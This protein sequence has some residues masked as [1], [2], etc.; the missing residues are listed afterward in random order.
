VHLFGRRVAKRQRFPS[1]RLLQL[2]TTTPTTKSQPSDVLLLLLRCAIVASAAF[3][4]AQPRFATANRQ[5]QERTP[6]RVVI[7]DTS[8]SMTRPTS[9]GR[10]AQDLAREIG[11]TLLDSAREGTVI[12]TGRPGANIRAAASWI[13]TRSGM[14]EV[15]VISDFQR[16]AV[17]DGDVAAVP[18]GVGIVF[19]KVPTSVQ[20][21]SVIDDSGL[22]VRIDPGTDDTD[23]TWRATSTSVAFPLT[24]L[25][26]P[27]D[28]SAA[29]SS[30]AAV[31]DRS[32]R[33]R[34]THSIAVVFP[35]YAG[36]GDLLRQVTPLHEPWQGEFLLALH[37]NHLFRDNTRGAETFSC[38]PDGAAL[39]RNGRG[40]A[41]AALGAGRSGSPY[42]LVVFSCLAPGTL[43]ATA[44]LAAVVDAASPEDRSGELEPTTV[45][46]ETL[47]QWERPSSDVAPRGVDTTS[48]DGRWLWLLALLLLGGEQW[49][50]RNTRR[51]VPEAMIAER[52]DRVA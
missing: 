5:R 10:P 9:N 14:R 3:A 24:V 40:S 20:A 32:P 28:D 51:R 33:A 35:G 48:P 43:A 1:L 30:I 29:R 12:Q 13:E 41:V 38:A 47:R 49:L 31:A 22:V 39:L 44:L 15:V 4:L 45:P 8:T 6:A 19:R 18:P 21:D 37:R 17:D 36:T 23:A 52:A 25:T 34:S 46:D 27:R 11:R 26:A 7:I 50:R 2:V 16:G 42:E